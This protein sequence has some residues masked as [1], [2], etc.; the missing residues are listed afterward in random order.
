MNFEFRQ[1]PLKPKALLLAVLISLFM[2]T[3]IIIMAGHNPLEVYDK[4]ITGALGSQFA[5]ASTI[6]WT[7]PPT[8]YRHRGGFCLSRRH[9]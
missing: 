7:T 9:V 1:E 3:L 4:M 8:V 2:S 5:V 6:R